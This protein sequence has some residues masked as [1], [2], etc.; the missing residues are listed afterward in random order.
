MHGYVDE[1]TKARLYGEAWV[2]LTASRSE[3]WSLTVMEAALCGTPSVALALGGLSE[4]IVDG[5]T[6]LLASDEQELV[7]LTRQLIDQPEL[8]DRLGDAAERR[9]RTFTWDRSAS[10]FL[11]V[12]R[13]VAGRDAL[14]VSTAP[15]ANGHAP[16]PAVD[17]A[18]ATEKRLA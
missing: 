1:P 11:E 3:G 14:P 10:A 6:G 13:R 5:E 15:S 17:A 2:N 16:A 4:S 9:A 18:E 8:R 7:R 12:L